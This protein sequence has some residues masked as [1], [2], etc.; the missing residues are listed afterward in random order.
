MGF[1]ASLGTRSTASQATAENS[2]GSIVYAKS[3]SGDLRQEP[4]RPIVRQNRLRLIESHKYAGDPEAFAHSSDRNTDVAAP[5]PAWGD[6]S[7][8]SN[9]LRQSTI[10]T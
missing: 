4:V 7:T 8:A 6:S 1:R 3:N 10:P 9:G 5:Q 2:S